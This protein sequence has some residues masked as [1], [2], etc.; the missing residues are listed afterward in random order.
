MSAVDPTIQTGRDACLNRVLLALGQSPAFPYTGS[1]QRLA[2][3][4]S[5]F[6][7]QTK[8]AFLMGWYFNTEPEVEVVPAGAGSTLTMP[9]GFL[10]MDPVDPELNLVIRGNTFYDLDRRSTNFSGYTSVKFV[11][12]K[13]LA[14]TETPEQFRTYV[15]ARTARVYT[16]RAEGENEYFA[17]LLDDETR[18]LAALQSWEFRSRDRTTFSY[19]PMAALHYRRNRRWY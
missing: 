12:I 7:E 2:D 11:G 15:I 1:N 10:N 9:N 14:I 3:I 8:E 18:A 13:G 4:E 19:P 5:T 6:D 16:Q 17:K